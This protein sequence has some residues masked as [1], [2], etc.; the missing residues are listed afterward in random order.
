MNRP[1]LEGADLRR[2]P[3]RRERRDRAVAGGP[4]H[5]PSPDRVSRRGLTPADRGD[6]RPRCHR[7]LR[8]D[9]SADPDARDDGGRRPR[10]ARAGGR[11][12]GR[13]RSAT[14]SAPGVT[15]RRRRRDQDRGG[16][17]R[18]GR[19]GAGRGS[20]SG[21]QDR[22]LERAAR[23]ACRGCPRSAPWSSPKTIRTSHGSS[24][25]RCARPATRRSSPS[26]A[27][28]RSPPCARTPR[29]CWCSI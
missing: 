12:A 22:D 19:R 28:R 14:G 8:A 15:C 2:V 17:D 11:S 5:R 18:G 3:R 9:A 7:R 16:V 29:T 4:R 6:P 21:R 20:V 25:P 13:A 26:T 1:R 24:T 27:S 23:T 10:S